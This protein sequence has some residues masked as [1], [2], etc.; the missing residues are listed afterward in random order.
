MVTGFR[1]AKANVGTVDLRSKPNQNVYP[2]NLFVMIDVPST[3]STERSTGQ[4][5]GRDLI[6]TVR[7]EVNRNEQ[8]QMEVLARKSINDNPFHLDFEDAGGI[9]SW[10][11]WVL[12]R[13]R[14]SHD[15]H[16]LSDRWFDISHTSNTGTVIS[17][18]FGFLRI[19]GRN[20]DGS[21]NNWEIPEI[22]KKYSKYLKEKREELQQKMDL[23]DAVIEYMDERTRIP[24]DI[25]PK[26]EEWLAIGRNNITDDG[27]IIRLPL[28]KDYDTLKVHENCQIT[29]SDRFGVEHNCHVWNGN[30]G[31]AL[32]RG[33]LILGIIN[34]DPLNIGYSDQ[35]TGFAVSSENFYDA[36]MRHRRSSDQEN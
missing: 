28:F 11:G 4:Y 21:P 30:S 12:Y 31:G 33:N 3:L 15:G 6:L 22:R 27:L 16:G 24:Q 36:V 1:S 32:I 14:A 26:F 25:Q 34:Y 35:F 2:Y 18:G 10:D 17:A 13:V 8:P 9:T 23:S 19:L 5:V 29:R 7:H 20:D